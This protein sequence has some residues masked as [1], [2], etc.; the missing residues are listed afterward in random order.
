MIRAK[1]VFNK[2]ELDRFKTLGQPKEDKEQGRKSSQAILSL[3]N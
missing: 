3:Q 2:K 1:Q